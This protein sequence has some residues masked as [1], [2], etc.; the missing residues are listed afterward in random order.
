MTA[1]EQINQATQGLD[2]LNTLEALQVMNKQDQKVAWAVQE[3]LE[4]LSF[5]IDQVAEQL[6]QGGRL[7]YIGAGTS[8]RLGVLDASECPPTFS[9]DPAMVQ[10]I[11]AG[12]DIALRDPVEGAE[13]DPEAGRQAIKDKAL[14]PK[15]ILIG[16][17]ASGGAP[18]VLG[19]LEEAKIRGSR[20]GCITCV[21]G[22][23]LGASGRV[24]CGG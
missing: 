6:K 8:G 14:G 11:I 7:F 22:S 23:K 2:Q 1:T 4:P 21:P 5:L 19:A 9:T 10:G 18:Y 16:L 17:S 13:D 20:T 12:G 3:A 24:P 15:D